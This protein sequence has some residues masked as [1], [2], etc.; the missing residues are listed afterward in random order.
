MTQGN[1]SLVRVETRDGVQVVVFDRPD[2]KNALTLEMYATAAAALRAAD[3]D[4]SVRVVVITGAGGIFT[5]GNDLGE[6]KE[7]P[8]T[9]KDTPTFDFLGELVRA[10]KPLIA[11]VP[12][13]AVGIGTTLLLHC[14]LVYAAESATFRMP[15]VD[16]GLCPEGASSFLLPRIMGHA[17][18]AELL[19]LGKRFDAAEAHALGLVNA[20]VPDGELHDRASEAAHALARKPPGAVRSTK[21]LL[22]RGSLAAV[23]RAL[24]EEGDA[25]L[26]R[27]QSPE[28]AEAFRAFFERRPPDFSPFE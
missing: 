17:R 7:S 19:L 12:G 23:R 4:L 26:E 13:A 14:D 24:E 11:A 6:F 25:F 16:L 5:A 21:E 8:P 2:K 10:R 28:A 18:A 22:R 1:A 3:E 20:V 9:S 27:L 15:F